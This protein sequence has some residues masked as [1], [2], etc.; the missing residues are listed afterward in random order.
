[1]QTAAETAGNIEQPPV[2][3]VPVDVLVSIRKV[4]PFVSVL[5]AVGAVYCVYAHYSDSKNLE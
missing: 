1:M 5:L 4:A 3:K 2:P